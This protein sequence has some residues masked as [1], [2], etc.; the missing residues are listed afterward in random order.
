M[1]VSGPRTV[2]RRM[3]EWMISRKGNGHGFISSTILA[4]SWT[5]PVKAT[6]GT[7][8]RTEIWARNLPDTIEGRWPVLRDGVI[9]EWRLHREAY[10]ICAECDSWSEASDFIRLRLDRQCWMN[11][12]LLFTMRW[13]R[14][15]GDKLKAT[16]CFSAAGDHIG[17]VYWL[18]SQVHNSGGSKPFFLCVKCFL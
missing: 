10:I 16:R 13:S 17:R 1:T 8:I 14:C 7:T 4:F 18:I 11:M 15:R 9:S 12:K 6:K 5:I 2:W 3:V